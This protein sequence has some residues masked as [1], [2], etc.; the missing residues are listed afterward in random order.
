MPPE[1]IVAACSLAGTLF[2]SICGIFVSSKL[3]NYR[4]DKLE[5]TMDKLEVKMDKHNNQIER[6]ARMEQ[7]NAAQWHAIKDLKGRLG[8][9]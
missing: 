6:L 3:I 2:G 8:N 7:D 5:I 1:I 9:V 4:I